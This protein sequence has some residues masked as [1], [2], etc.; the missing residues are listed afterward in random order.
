MKE[1]ARSHTQRPSI[2]EKDRQ[3]EWQIMH[4]IHKLIS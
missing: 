1:K 2:R 4:E 3:N